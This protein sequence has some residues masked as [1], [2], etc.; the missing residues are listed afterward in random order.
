MNKYII[1]AISASLSA[2]VIAANLF[3]GVK[4]D[5]GS[6]VFPSS[7]PVY[8][9][10][11]TSEVL[12]ELEPY[13]QINDHFVGWL[14]NRSQIN[15]AVT[16]SEDC[17]FYL[18]HN[19]SKAHS[20]NGIPFLGSDCSFN[21]LNTVIYGSDN[22][23]FSSLWEYCD[24]NYLESNPNIE[25]STLYEKD[26]YKIYAVIKGSRLSLESS[27][28][29]L[30]SDRTQVTKKQFNDYISAVLDTASVKTD[31]LPQYGSRLLTLCTYDTDENSQCVAVL[32]Y[33]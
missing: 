12:A 18:N 29:S 26:E 8:T 15:I 9:S 4:N 11:D 31:L 25:F 19:L 3:I 10:P 16:K 30:S 20:E 32:A 24:S 2:A 6:A 14:D 1:K 17:E 23:I 5:S 27:V 13:L 22:G 21:S 33:A 7:A 28:L